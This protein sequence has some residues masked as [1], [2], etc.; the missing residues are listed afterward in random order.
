M[1]L[2]LT[3]NFKLMVLLQAGNWK[4]D[5]KQAVEHNLQG[6]TMGSK[7][8]TGSPGGE[9]NRPIGDQGQI[10]SLAFPWGDNRGIR[11]GRMRER[12]TVLLHRESVGVVHVG[13]FEMINIALN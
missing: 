4:H 6:R 5:G 1:Q 2:L 11:G 3:A 9:E 12:R 8:C 13:L 7:S 10:Q